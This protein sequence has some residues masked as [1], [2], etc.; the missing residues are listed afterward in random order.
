MNGSN[1]KR[2]DLVCNNDSHSMYSND[3][4]IPNVEFHCKNRITTN[5]TNCNFTSAESDGKNTVMYE[6]CNSDSQDI[7]VESAISVNPH[8]R[9]SIESNQNAMCQNAVDRANDEGVEKP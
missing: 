9:N 1:F 6:N 3:A 8:I 4:F 5:L 7:S 2:D